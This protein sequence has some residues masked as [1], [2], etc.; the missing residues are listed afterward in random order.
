ML[1][2]ESAQPRRSRLSSDVWS[3]KSVMMSSRVPSSESAFPERS[4]DRI[5][6]FVSKKGPMLSMAFSL[7]FK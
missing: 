1:V 5:D 6:A 2:P 3:R 7:A 4:S